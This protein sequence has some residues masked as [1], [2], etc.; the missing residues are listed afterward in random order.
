MP[1]RA[2]A[3]ET[4][5]RP[6]AS[7]NGETSYGRASP[8][9]SRPFLSRAARYH[10]LMLKKPHW[11]SGVAVAC[12]SS[13]RVAA[14]VVA[15]PPASAA[16]AR[17]R[18]A[19]R[20][21]SAYHRRGACFMPGAR[22]NHRPKTATSRGRRRI[23]IRGERYISILSAR[24]PMWRRKRR[25]IFHDV[26]LMAENIF[27]PPGGLRRKTKYRSAASCG[28]GIS[29]SS[30]PPARRAARSAWPA[31]FGCREGRS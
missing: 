19:L 11:A 7:N 27:A 28:N 29:R 16:V 10:R 15:A 23:G 12:T 24:A 20:A 3:N 30:C 9:F 13:Q 2:E 18:V 26:K 21:S 22:R 17:R 14:A 31:A 25:G 5:A 1:A 6:S 4:P 8:L